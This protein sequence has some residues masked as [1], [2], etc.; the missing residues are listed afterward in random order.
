MPNV[1]SA[2]SE[3]AEQ[4]CLSGIEHG[5]TVLIHSNIKRTLVKIRRK[6][7]KISP[8]DILQSFLQSVGS[9]GTLI[10]PL[11]NFDFPKTRH[12]DFRNT[13][14]QM[15]VLTEAGR[16]YPG[17]IRT[18]HPIYSFA[19]IGSN[20]RL[21]ESVDN[22]SG[23]GEDSP[24]ALLRSMDGKIG[25]IDLDDQNSMTFYHHIEEMLNVPYRYFKDF[26]GTYVNIAGESSTKS[27]CLYVRDI[28][29]GVLTHV[30]PA[31]EL[32]WE[33]GL[34]KGSRPLVG[35]GLRTVKAREM[36]D[37]VSSIIENGKAN[38]TLFRYEE[39]K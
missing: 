11:F 8:E 32:M 15:G 16:L 34:Y 31:G 38:G 37:Y 24:F 10:L 30:N 22:H 19:V 3:L 35:S 14:S 1:E 33:E 20:S 39:I 18:G 5:D 17:A 13:P 29:R 6:G 2:I 27:Y 21:F 23:Y 36:F 25:S 26:S 12:F 9:N 28:D 4:W 7:V